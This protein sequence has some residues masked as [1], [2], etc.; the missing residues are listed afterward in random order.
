[1]TIFK[2]PIPLGSLSGNDWLAFK[3]WLA[4]SISCV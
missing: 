2:G 4:K 1:M 3:V